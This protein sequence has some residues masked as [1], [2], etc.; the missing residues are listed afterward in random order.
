MILIRNFVFILL[1]SVSFCF[2]QHD[3]VSSKM[4]I[5]G[6]ININ[7]HTADFYKLAGI[8]NCCPHFESGSGIGY[9]AGLLF[10]YK[11]NN[12]F[13][14]GGRLGIM[15]LDGE[16]TKEE[17]TTILLETGPAE[18]KFEHKMTGSFLNAGFEPSI[19]YNPIGRLQL[20]AGARF[21]INLTK[22]YD[23]VETITEPNGQGTFLD[24][25]GNDTFSRTRNKYS[26]EI[27]DAIPFQMFL[28]GGISYEL[29]LNRE[30]S[31]L[32][33]PEVSYYFPI[34][35]LVNNTDWKVSSLR[36]GISIK[37]APISKPL[38]EKIF[39][40]EELIDTI[41]IESELIAENIFKAGI[42]DISTIEFESEIEI[43]TTET[44]RRTDTLFHPKKYHL[45]G[46]ITA[47]GID[48]SGKEIENPIFIIEEFIS[49]RLD[50]LLN[51]VFFDENSPKLPERYRLL[52]KN[53]TQSF[54]IN[55]LY[56]ESTLDIYYNILNIV[57]KRMTLY[58]DSKITLIGCNSGMEGEKNNTDLSRN[59]AESVKDYLINIWSISPDR[60]AL[61]SRNL[62]G[63]ASTPIQEPDKVEENRRVEIYSDDYRILEPVFIQKIDRTANPPVVRFKPTTESKAGLSNWRISANQNSIPG[64]GF[65]EKGNAP[66]P[67]YVDWKLEVFQKII[68]K[69]PEP[70]IYKLE[71]EDIKGNTKTIAN[72]TLSIDVVTVQEKRKNRIGD[73]EIE[74]FSLILFDFDESQIHGNN[75][76]I[77]D[78]IKDRIK[79]ESSIQINGYTDR[80]GDAEYNKKLSARR[81]DAAKSALKREDASSRGI[82]EESLL[83]D[84]DIPEGR[85]YCRTVVITVKTKV[86]N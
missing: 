60:I 45:N 12:S 57:G 39:R 44:I 2:A 53:E 58:P 41:R 31:L 25:L 5:Y 29:P 8:P 79:P 36:A 49:N 77:I 85:F 64:E 69:S 65:T 28:N 48:S 72:K 55:S 32:L 46:T 14:L 11:L 83:Y 42:E 86:S 17:P 84:N 67:A 54:E 35:E 66:I 74:K 82:G 59:R 50:P 63:K 34:T 9:N 80:T 52:T 24:S 30:G 37:F 78:F 27:P 68:P 43:I 73:Y 61:K 40:K 1:T 15:S 56:R 13:W 71:L 18:G 19:I 75:E 26:G 10:E 6:G 47:V 33:V 70:I 62:P 76:K 7:N 3:S 23:Q 38:K 4:G 16:L 22:E 21:G 20:S 51:Y 81:V